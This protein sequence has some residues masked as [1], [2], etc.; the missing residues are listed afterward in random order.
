MEWSINTEKVFIF[1]IKN[2]IM[3]GKFYRECKIGRRIL[4]KI[5]QERSDVYLQDLIKVANCIGCNITDLI[6]EKTHSEI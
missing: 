4:Q 6:I 2:N 5:L 1:M 3:R